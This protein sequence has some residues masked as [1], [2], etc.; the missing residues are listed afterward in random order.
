MRASCRPQMQDKRYHLLVTG[1]AVGLYTLPYILGRCSFPTEYYTA[2]ESRSSLMLLAFAL[3]PIVA[4]L[5]SAFA[6]W[7]AIAPRLCAATGHD[8]EGKRYAAIILATGILCLALEVMPRTAGIQLLNYH[9]LFFARPVYVPLYLIFLTIV[10]ALLV[11][12]HGRMKDV[13][14]RWVCLAWLTGSVCLHL[15]ARCLPEASPPNVG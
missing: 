11:S 13:L 2:T 9:V 1:L 4:Y 8:K 10:L 5:M 6:L 12:W 14:V 3:L 15:V 7:C